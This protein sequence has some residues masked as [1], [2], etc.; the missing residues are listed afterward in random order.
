MTS[1]ITAFYIP[2]KVDVNIHPAKTEVNFQDA[3]TNLL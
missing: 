2:I 1:I 3:T